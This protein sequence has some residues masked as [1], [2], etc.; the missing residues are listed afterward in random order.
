MTILAKMGSIG[1]SVL[2]IFKNT[3]Y[4]FKTEN[5]LL[6]LKAANSLVPVTSHF[7]VIKGSVQTDGSENIHCSQHC[8]SV[9]KKK[10]K[11]NSCRMS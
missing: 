3:L 11:T 8:T 2:C 9:D 7:S 5:P 4:T 1:Q 10:S 6:L